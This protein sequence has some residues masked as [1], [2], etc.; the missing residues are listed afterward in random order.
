MHNNTDYIRMHTLDDDDNIMMT[1][2]PITGSRLQVVKINYYVTT[3]ENFEYR[4]NVIHSV[5]V[6]INGFS[7]TDIL[8]LLK[9]KLILFHT[10]ILPKRSLFLIAGHIISFTCSL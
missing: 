8:I 5:F 7:T 3:Y 2:H 10:T 1:F 4:N 6:P 9:D